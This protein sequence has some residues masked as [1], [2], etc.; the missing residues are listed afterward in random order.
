M[1]R[2]YLIIP[3]LNSSRESIPPR[4]LPHP[5]ADPVDPVAA[6]PP[7]DPVA[8]HPTLVHL[9]GLALS[10]E[11]NA[12]LR[13]LLKGSKL[14]RMP[15][16]H[17][18]RKPGVAAVPL[19]PVHLAVG[20]AQVALGLPP[21]K[22][23]NKRLPVDPAANLPLAVE[24]TQSALVGAAVALPPVHLAVE[25]AQSALVGPAVALPPVHLSVEAAQSTLLGPV[26][27][28]SLVHRA[29]EAA[30]PAQS[31]Q[32][33]R[34]AHWAQ[35]L[36]N[37]RWPLVRRV[38][39]QTLT[40]TWL[41]RIASISPRTTICMRVPVNSRTEDT[42]PCFPP[43][44]HQPLEGNDQGRRAEEEASGTRKRRYQVA[45]GHEFNAK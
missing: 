39:R 16:R 10:K 25:A 3:P 32:P 20:A 40:I 17:L 35:F 21:P 37:S 18:S 8:H 6:V 41:K 13:T 2:L 36:G 44:H 43:V 15:R 7:G 28:L 30:H 33:A 9:V 22:K 29:A 42:L 34:E 38:A 11:A 1:P 24:A 45:E 31:V 14:P 26:V 27:T 23:A 19:P 5:I 4:R 12:K